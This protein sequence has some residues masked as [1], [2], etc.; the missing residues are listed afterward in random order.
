MKIRNKFGKQ[1]EYLLLNV[2]P[3]IAGVSEWDK[4]HE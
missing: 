3:L 4:D 1:G 2:A